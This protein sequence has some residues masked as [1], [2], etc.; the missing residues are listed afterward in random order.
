MD[1]DDDGDLDIFIGGRIQPGYYIQPPQSYIL[2]NIGGSDSTL[3]F[4]DVTAKVAPE[5]QNLG[6]VTD[7]LWFDYNDD[8]NNDLILAG[9]WMPITFFENDGS[10]F[11]NVTEKLNFENT[12]GWWNAIEATD[13]DN[14]GDLDLI[15]GNL[16]LNSKY[17]STQESPFEIY[18]NDFD[19][20]NRQDIV[21]SVTKKGVKLPVRGRECSS[22]Q[23]PMIKRNFETYASFASATLEDIYG[24]GM[25]EKS[26]H[27]SVNTFA[28]HWFENK[29]KGKFEMHQL[30]IESQFSSINDIVVFDYNEDGFP[31]FL[32]A[33]N[34][35]DTE[36]ETPRSDSSIGLVL[37]NDG[38]KGFLSIPMIE[39]GLLINKEAKVIAP[40]KL[41]N[42]DESGF[43]L[44]LN[45]DSLK[46][47]KFQP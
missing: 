17:K 15:A 24:K 1:F 6:M 35:Y 18:V 45:N 16:G 14:D 10:Q 39:S 46:V 40:I 47:L 31:D 37:Q 34:L 2:E 11:V 25:L 3:R 42:T 41:G 7:A 4:K 21:L 32:V 38:K 19:E 36:V 29:T 20:N 26:T 13:V 30:P 9:E 8:G 33:G 44:G 43:V 5:L 12:V 27:K 22:Q 28:H 23:I